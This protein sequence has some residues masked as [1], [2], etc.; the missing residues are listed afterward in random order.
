ME[1]EVGVKAA[2]GGELPKADDGG[3]RVAGLPKA[4][5]GAEVGEEAGVGT[6][7]EMAEAGVKGEA[8]VTARRRR[9]RLERQGAR[10][11]WPMH[12]GSMQVKAEGLA[13]K[14]VSRSTARRW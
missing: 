14:H 1:E 12:E 11:G 13:C 9:E 7:K 2:L 8:C 3:A 6:G 10:L 5:A 4:D